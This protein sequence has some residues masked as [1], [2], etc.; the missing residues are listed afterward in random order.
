[1]AYNS[2]PTCDFCAF[3]KLNANLNKDRCEY[4]NKQA[5]VK[6]IRARE[7]VVI[8]CYLT[9]HR[10]RIFEKYSKTFT[11]INYCPQC[12]RLLKNEKKFKK[13]RK[14]SEDGDKE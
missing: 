9:D 13:R 12:G 14:E 4:Y 8:N 6:S 3:L 7:G 5:H 2:D 1:M 10:K 11:P